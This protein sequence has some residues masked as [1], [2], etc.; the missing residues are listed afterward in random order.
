MK[1][2]FVLTFLFHLFALSLVLFPKGVKGA[3]VMTISSVPIRVLDLASF[4][5]LICGSIFL[6]YTLFRMLSRQ[7]A[8]AANTDEEKIDRSI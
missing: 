1:E 6:Y 3:V 4:I 8:A 2:R 5:L 7:Q